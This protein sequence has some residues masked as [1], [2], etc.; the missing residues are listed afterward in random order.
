MRRRQSCL[1][2][3]LWNG[4]SVLAKYKKMPFKR[5][6]NL[7]LGADFKYFDKYHCIERDLKGLSYGLI[8][9]VYF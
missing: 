9:K 4:L 7:G 3:T 1:H 8:A 2:T 5:T 6:D